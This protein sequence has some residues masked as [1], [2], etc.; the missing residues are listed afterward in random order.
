M[1]PMKSIFL[2]R[3][4]LFTKISIPPQYADAFIDTSGEILEIGNIPHQR[5]KPLRAE[6]FGGGIKFIPVSSGDQYRGAIFQEILRAGK[7]YSVASPGDYHPFV[8]KHGCDHGYRV[9][10]QLPFFQIS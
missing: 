5:E 10:R 7:T 2:A 6:S 9:P 4:A 8:F 1:S 3:P